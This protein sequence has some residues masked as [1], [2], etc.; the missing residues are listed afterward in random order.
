MALTEAQKRANK[1]YA[2]KNRELKNYNSK[3]SHAKNFIQKLA[4]KE[5]LEFLKEEIEKRL[6]E[7]LK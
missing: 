5:D 3:K 2:E 6:N 4:K 1:K 7:D